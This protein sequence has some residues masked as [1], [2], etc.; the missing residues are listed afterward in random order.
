MGVTW[1]VTLREQHRL[2]VSQN[3][4]LYCLLLIKEDIW[5]EGGCCSRAVEETR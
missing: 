4:M 2:R 1:S 3:R 5:A